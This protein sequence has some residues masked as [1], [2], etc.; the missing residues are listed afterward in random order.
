[1]P[2]EELHG[3][4]IFSRLSNNYNIIQ[5]YLEMIDKPFIDWMNK[6]VYNIALIVRVSEQV[7]SS[8]IEAH[9]KQRAE[10]RD[11]LTSEKNFENSEVFVHKTRKIHMY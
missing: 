8:A 9:E 7:H 1:M 10:A 4:N 6:Q 11:K 3:S 2:T 5:P